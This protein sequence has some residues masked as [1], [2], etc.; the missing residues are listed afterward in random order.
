MSQLLNTTP[1]ADGYRMP[2]EW[3]PQTRCWMHWPERTDTWRMGAKP[4]QAA[5]AEVA[6]AIAEFEPVTVCASPGHF[7]NASAVLSHP[8]IRVVELSHDD[9]WMRDTG[10]IFVVNDKGGLRGIDWEFD[11]YGGLVDGLYFP[12]DQDDKVAHKMLAIEHCDRYRSK[13]FVLEGGAV[14]TDGEGTILTTDEVMLRPGRNAEFDREAND[15]FLKDYLNADKVLWVKRGIYL[16]ETKGHIDNMACFV[17]PG[18]VVLAWCDDKDDPQYERSQEAYEYLSGQT[19]ARGRPLEVHKLPL[20]KP[21]FTTEED[22]EG[23]DISETAE[24]RPIGTRLGASYINF[25][26]CNGGV[27]MPSFDDP[28]DDIAAGILQGL[29]PERKVVQVPGREILLGGGNIHCITMQ[30]PAP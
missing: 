11:A 15:A 29:M 4:A 8:N 2:A 26:I 30:Q 13:G 14:H 20:P 17:R 24:D 21:M 22:C 18:V 16:D 5:Y 23:I 25:L 6:R 9:A 12:W 28:N 1:S 7:E 3:H 10:A 19:D 27:V